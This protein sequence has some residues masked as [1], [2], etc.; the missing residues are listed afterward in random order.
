VRNQSE[1][2]IPESLP[3]DTRPIEF[4]TENGFSVLRLW[5]IDRG[6]PPSEGHYRFLVVDPRDLKR[7]IEVEIAGDIAVQ[8]ALRTR[9]RILAD[10]SYWICCAER[11]LAT[12][13]W[14]NNDYPSD[15]RLRVSLLDPE[16]IIVAIRW[17]TG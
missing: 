11:H 14:E 17:G 12:Y 9:G 16:D 15:D 13:L 8:I 10:S 1:R 3:A 6:L 7:Q 2:S 5:E 4:V